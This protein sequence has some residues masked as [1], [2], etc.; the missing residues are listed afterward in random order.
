[1]TGLPVGPYTIMGCPFCDFSGGGRVFA[2]FLFLRR[3]ASF[4]R[5]FCARDNAVV[6]ADDDDDPTNR[7]PHSLFLIP[8][9]MVRCDVSTTKD[10]DFGG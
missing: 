6:E 5:R 7:R 9:I 2:S 8:A 3:L 4:L 10:K 1:M